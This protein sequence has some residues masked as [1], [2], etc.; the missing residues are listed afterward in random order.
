MKSIDTLLAE[1]IGKMSPTTLGKYNERVAG[2]KLPQENLVNIAESLVAQ[3]GQRSPIR[4]NNGSQGVVDESAR[5]RQES[6]DLLMEAIAKR[7]PAFASAYQLVKE[8]SGHASNLT[9]S[10]KKE[11]EWLLA[12]G[13]SEAD[14]TKAVKL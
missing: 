7:D 3:E 10:Q 13:M 8:T 1:A 4:R 12:I 5:L 2:K 14:A 11:R 9:E 6:D